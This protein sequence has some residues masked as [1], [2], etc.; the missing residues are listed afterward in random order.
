MTFVILTPALACP[1]L[2]KKGDS[3]EVLL[4]AKTRDVND[5][6]NLTYSV[7]KAKKEKSIDKIRN[8]H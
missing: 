4:A 8:S 1:S 7:W 5:L 2:A 3:I 6:S